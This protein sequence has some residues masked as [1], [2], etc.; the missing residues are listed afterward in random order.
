MNR[1]PQDLEQTIKTDVEKTICP[2]HGEHPMITFTSEG[3]NVSCC[4]DEFREETISTCKKAMRDALR[5]YT[6]Q[7]LGLR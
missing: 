6:A 5:E 2:I 4:C 3:I 7:L 1:L